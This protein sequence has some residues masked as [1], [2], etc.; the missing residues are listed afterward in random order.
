MSALDHRM[1]SAK[2]DALTAR[3]LEL[4]EYHDGKDDVKT[5]HGIAEAMGALAA[6]RRQAFQARVKARE[7][8]SR[9]PVLVFGKPYT[10]AQA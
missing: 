1:S 4:W 2:L 5:A 7:Q 3:L 10:P 6:A 8:R 9:K